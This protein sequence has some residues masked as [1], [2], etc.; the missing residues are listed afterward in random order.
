MDSLLAAHGGCMAHGVRCA[1]RYWL[2]TRRGLRWI[3]PTIEWY[4]AWQETRLR[5]Q[6][7]TC[8]N[9][10]PGFGGV[11][12]HIVGKHQMSHG[13]WDVEQVKDT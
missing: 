1:W 5:R 9:Q 12:N 3:D 8:P 7:A 13:L 4:R 6:V 11:C 2:L 10:N